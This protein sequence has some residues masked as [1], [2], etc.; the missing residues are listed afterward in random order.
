MKIFFEQKGKFNLKTK[1]NEFC[2]FNQPHSLPLSLSNVASVPLTAFKRITIFVNR[3]L[4]SDR[5][6]G[7]IDR[8]RDSFFGPKARE[9]FDLLAIFD[10]TATL[11]SSKLPISN[12]HRHRHPIRFDSIPIADRSRQLLFLSGYAFR[13]RKSERERE[14][15]ERAEFAIKN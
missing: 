13:P 6:T 8:Q 2:V 15:E 11:I 14:R 10:S 4:A 9:Q 12:H 3:K 5:L 7:F 1:A